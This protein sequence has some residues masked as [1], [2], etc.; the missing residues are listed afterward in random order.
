[1]CGGDQID[2]VVMDV[3][4]AF[5]VVPHKRLLSKLDYYGIRGSTRVDNKTFFR[6]V[7]SKS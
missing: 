4:K 5:D 7:H 3:S 1:M 6:I 2:I